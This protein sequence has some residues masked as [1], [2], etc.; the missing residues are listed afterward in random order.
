MPTSSVG[1]RIRDER[2]KRG[3]SLRALARA[4]GVSPSLI[5]RSRRPSRSRP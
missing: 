3:M 5:S 4:V 2:L 1:Q